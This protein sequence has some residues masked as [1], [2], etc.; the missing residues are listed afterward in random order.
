MEIF[1][2]G[3]QDSENGEQKLDITV[4]PYPCTVRD[5]ITDVFYYKESKY[6]DWNHIITR[7]WDLQKEPF[8]CSKSSEPAI[9]LLPHYA[10]GTPQWL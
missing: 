8:S 5:F 1:Q 10:L 2:G 9:A 3:F 6:S 7:D 4:T